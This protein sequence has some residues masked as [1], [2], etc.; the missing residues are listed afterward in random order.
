MIRAAVL[1]LVMYAVL[2]ALF[3]ES[4]VI[5]AAITIPLALIV[6]WGFMSGQLRA[7]CPYC[8][9]SV[10]LGASV[11]HHCGREVVTPGS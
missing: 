5:A 11:C 3:D 7:T 1:L 8:R 2:Y 9:K 10:K 4:S 6:A